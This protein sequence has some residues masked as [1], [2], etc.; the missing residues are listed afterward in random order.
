MAKEVVTRCDVCGGEPASSF[1]IAT[2][3]G[4]AEID[5]CQK[6]AAPLLRLYQKGRVRT[7]PVRSGSGTHGNQIQ[8]LEALV[9]G[10][11]EG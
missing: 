11:P 3:A 5:L 8:A 1:S 4:T 9:R 7:T 6:H 2:D 10:V